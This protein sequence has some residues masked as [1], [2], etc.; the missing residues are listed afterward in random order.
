MSQKTG[1]TID[2]SDPHLPH[3]GMKNPK[4]QP[5]KLGDGNPTDCSYAN[6]GSGA[7]APKMAVM[8]KGPKRNQ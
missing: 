8:H 3:R 4:A 1:R 2:K 5:H 7:S 6:D